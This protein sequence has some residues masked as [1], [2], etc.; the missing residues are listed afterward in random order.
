M[1]MELEKA[2]FLRDMTMSSTL[3]HSATSCVPY[4]DKFRVWGILPLPMTEPAAQALRS[5]EL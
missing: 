3:K 2:W 5:T 4:R 1:F